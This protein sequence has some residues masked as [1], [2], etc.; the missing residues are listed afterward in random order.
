MLQAIF[1]IFRTMP[2]KK[3]KRE[4]YNRDTKPLKTAAVVGTR[5]GAHMHKKGEDVPF[6]EAFVSTCKPSDSVHTDTAE[7]FVNWKE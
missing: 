7:L 3:G 4:K 1:H 2:R 6:L 5:L